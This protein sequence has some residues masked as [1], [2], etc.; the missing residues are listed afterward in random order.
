MPSR[1]AKR[2]TEVSTRRP[3]R[4]ALA[5]RARPMLQLES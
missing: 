2:A 5:T 4:E 1:S 3:R